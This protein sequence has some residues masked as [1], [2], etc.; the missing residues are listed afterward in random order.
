[1]KLLVGTDIESVDKFKKL[2][3]LKKKLIKRIFFESEYNY[4][5]NKVNSDQSLAGIWCAKE[6]VVKSFSEFNI[7]TVREVEIIC[8]KNCAPK[9][10]IKNLKVKDLNFNISVSISHTKEYA[11]AIAVLTIFE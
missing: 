7:I 3:N 1:M 11:T 4:A 8:E 9:A 6:A 10:V 2:I 5:I